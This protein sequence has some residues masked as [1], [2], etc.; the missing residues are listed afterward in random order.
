MKNADLHV[1][2][3]ISDGSCTIGELAAAGARAGA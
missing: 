1:H 3:R 2:S